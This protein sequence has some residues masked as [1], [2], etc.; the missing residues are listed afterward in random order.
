MR[1]DGKEIFW[2]WRALSLKEQKLLSTLRNRAQNLYLKYYLIFG[3]KD[4]NSAICDLIVDE[5]ASLRNEVEEMLIEAFK[6]E[7]S[8]SSAGVSKK[9]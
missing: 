9:P 6:K 7:Y 8:T 3:I 4:V 5:S 1:R 2:K